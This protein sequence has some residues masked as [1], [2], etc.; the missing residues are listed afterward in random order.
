[1]ALA[2]MAGIPGVVLIPE[3]EMRLRSGVPPG[4][5]STLGWAILL[6]R[7][8]WPK[9]WP[10]TWPIR[11]SGTSLLLM[12]LRQTVEPAQAI[13]Q[14]AETI[15][16]GVAEYTEPGQALVRRLR[17]GPERGLPVACSRLSTRTR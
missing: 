9:V 8:G 15:R 17:L 1:M 2:I 5:E 4:P 11:S 12:A 3:W 7:P 14:R 6:D 16:D 13:H 10:E